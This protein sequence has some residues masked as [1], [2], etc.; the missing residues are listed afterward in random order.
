M[1]ATNKMIIES[2]KIEHDITCPLHTYLKWKQLGYQVKKGQKSEHKITIWK[3][4]TKKTRNK[5]TGLEEVSN[6]MILTTACFF[7]IEQVEAIQK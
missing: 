5:E 4:T 2:Y 6:K 7:T 3:S 1:A